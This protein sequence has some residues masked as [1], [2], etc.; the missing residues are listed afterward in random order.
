MF[1]FRED[2]KKHWDRVYKGTLLNEVGWFQKHPAISLKLIAATG[3]SIEGSIIDVG[4]G[5]SKLPE[6]LLDKGFKRITVLD[7][8]ESA[9]E[10]AKSQMG[11][12]A[13][14]IVW[15]EADVIKYRFIEK[16]RCLA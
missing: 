14:A 9:I 6:I 16:V 13:R 12:R 3:T 11:K 8:S 4:G 10:K 5:T 7:I 1:S 15:I 2:I